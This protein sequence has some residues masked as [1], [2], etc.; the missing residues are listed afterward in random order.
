MVLLDIEMPGKTGLEVAD[1]IR[2]SGINTMIV[3]ITAYNKFA[4]D[5]FKVSAF[6]YLLKPV[7]HQTMDELLH[8]FYSQRQYY[9]LNSRLDSLFDLMKNE[10]KI[11]INTRHGFYM[12]NA[13]N[14]LFI[15]SEG[16]YCVFHHA[17]NK[18]DTVS[19]NLGS[20]EEVLPQNNFFRISRSIIINLDYL[21]SVD[22]KTKTCVISRSDFEKTFNITGDRL[23]LLDVKM[24]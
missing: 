21:E 17:G 10:K 1:D 9:N 6:D 23:K 20:L 5:A 24:R 2:K 11:R 19:A 15:E 22:R 14:L 8:R 18:T 3:F 16:S 12:I 13:E 7:D 4:V